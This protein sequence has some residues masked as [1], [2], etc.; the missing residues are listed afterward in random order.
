[1]RFSKLVLDAR[2]CR[3]RV[4]HAGAGMSVEPPPYDP[5]DNVLEEVRYSMVD[6]GYADLVEPEVTWCP[7]R[8]CTD[9]DDGDKRGAKHGKIYATLEG[10]SCACS[11]GHSRIEVYRTLG[12]E[13]DVEIAERDAKLEGDPPPIEVGLSGDALLKLAQ[14]R[15]P[16][17]PLPGFFDPEPSL[18][19]VHGVAKVGKSTFCWNLSLAWAQGIAPWTGAAELPGSRV[20][21]LSAEQGARKAVRVMRRLT[22]SAG[23]GTFEDWAPSVQLVG[24]R[25]GMT[26]DERRI[27]CLDDEGLDVLA[28]VLTEARIA[29]DPIGL[30]TADSLSRLKPSGAETNSNDDMVALLSPLAAIAQEMS[31]YVLLVHHGGHAADRRGDPISGVRGASA[32]RDV[33]QVLMSVDLVKDDP[34]QRLVR[35]AGNEVSTGMHA[36]TVAR[37]YE[38][39]GNINRFEL[40]EAWAPDLEKAFAVGPLALSEFGRRALGWAPDRAPSGAAKKKARTILEDHVNRGILR[41][42]G[43][44]WELIRD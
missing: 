26:D 25:R 36:F 32:I 17:S 31:T 40:S 14:E 2:G 6:S 39:E 27:L 19:L 10:R 4:S 22:G 33:P 29:G 9:Q 16:T 35:V 37:D 13:M 8:E 41:R 43:S 3:D 38:P 5:I 42:S 1:M 21:I 34:R 44:A 20:L 23:L 28:R 12:R 11:R 15:D 7:V 18:H 24:S 30:V